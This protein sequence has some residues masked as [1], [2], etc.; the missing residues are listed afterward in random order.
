M[1]THVHVLACFFMSPC[2]K[3]CTSLTANSLT[4]E[5]IYSVGFSNLVLKFNHLELGFKWITR[6]DI[7]CHTLLPP[8]VRAFYKVLR[9]FPLPFSHGEF[10][11]GWSTSE[12]LHTFSHACHIFQTLLHEHPT[13]EYPHPY[14]WWKPGERE[15]WQKLRRTFALP[16]AHPQSGSDKTSFAW[17]QDPI[18]TPVSAYG[19]SSGTQ[20]FAYWTKTDFSASMSQFTRQQMALIEPSLSK[21]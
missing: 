16:K 7:W 4:A 8:L 5:F 1:H 15:P 20:Q 19:S 12:L 2:L 14:Q 17:E 10:T 13:E 18:L 6:C 9:R 11:A 21:A 3:T